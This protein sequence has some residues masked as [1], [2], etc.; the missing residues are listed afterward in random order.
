MSRFEAGWNGRPPFLSGTTQ[1]LAASLLAAGSRPGQT[2]SRNASP[3]FRRRHLRL[4]EPAVSA[5]RRIPFAAGPTP[6]TMRP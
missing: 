2:R 5:P 6:G 4:A 3:P 1:L